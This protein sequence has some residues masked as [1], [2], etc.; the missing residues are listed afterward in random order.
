[1]EHDD[2]LK[3]VRKSLMGAPLF[4]QDVPRT[5]ADANPVNWQES[6]VIP[7]EGGYPD[8]K[9]N[10]LWLASDAGMSGPSNVQRYEQTQAGGA[11]QV[12][13]QDTYRSGSTGA[14]NGHVEGER[15][16]LVTESPHLPSPPPERDRPEF[17]ITR[18]PLPALPKNDQ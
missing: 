16:G 4:K 8:F 10:A 1:M 6:R 2:L 13:S 7:E 14:M 9:N 17:S 15:S 3:G 18:K 12:P 5:V 11:E